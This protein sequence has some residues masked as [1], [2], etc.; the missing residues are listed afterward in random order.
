ML[1]WV[2][3]SKVLCSGVFIYIKLLLRLFLKGTR[4]K[5]F[6]NVKNQISEI[7]SNYYYSFSIGHRQKPLVIL[8]VTGISKPGNKCGTDRLVSEDAWL[9]VIQNAVYAYLFFMNKNIS[10]SRFLYLRF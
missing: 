8:A 2:T 4:I 9:H 3:M 7:F 5:N 10:T 6:D 1:T